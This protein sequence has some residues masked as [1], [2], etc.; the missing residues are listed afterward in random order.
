[1]DDLRVVLQQKIVSA[2]PDTKVTGNTPAVIG[3]ELRI[4]L[5]VLARL[6][7]RLKHIEIV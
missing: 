5:T 7:L 4:S 2:I 3:P 6:S 1:M